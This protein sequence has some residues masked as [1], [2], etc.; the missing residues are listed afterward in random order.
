MSLTYSCEWKRKEPASKPEDASSNA[1]NEAIVDDT[2]LDPLSCLPD[3]QQLI[4][5]HFNGQDL[6][7][8]SEVCPTWCNLIAD[9]PETMKK[10]KLNC[11]M[12]QPK[13]HQEKLSFIEAM[14][15]SCRNYINMNVAYDAGT[16][17][18][19]L[20]IMRKSA[21]TVERLEIGE[22][23]ACELSIEPEEWTR[24]K[25]VK[26]GNVSH[27]VLSFVLDSRLQ[28]HTLILDRCFQMNHKS[29][30]VAEFLSHQ[31]ELQALYIMA[32]NPL[33]LFM[34]QELLNDQGDFQAAPFQLKNLYV[35]AEFSIP[36]GAFELMV[37]GLTTFL[38]SQT[39][40][41]KLM[42]LCLPDRQI[43]GQIFRQLPALTSLSLLC[44]PH[45]F[46]EGAGDIDLTVNHHI[47]ELRVAREFP[48]AEIEAM[49]LH[50]PQLKIL[51]IQTLTNFLI[52][53]A[54]RFLAKLELLE[55]N[56]IENEDYYEQLKLACQQF[57]FGKLNKK[58]IVR[59]FEVPSGSIYEEDF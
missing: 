4:T 53:C 23:S 31:N 49:I 11:S 54:A 25:R 17:E 56:E 30:I 40:M 2:N 16:Q 13:S 43:L 41:E 57:F 21:K 47:T 58:I 8:M 42:L 46:F 26:L 39:K 22:I 45:Y 28:L 6:L 44:T 33:L 1:R 19:V 52:K 12:A 34:M 9:M 29:E 50:L 55:Y 14:D 5:Q 48:A 36:L 38:Q 18:D 59:K 24:L 51:G 37:V 15:G 35:G 27:S 20:Q 3:A 10:V 32:V 7:V